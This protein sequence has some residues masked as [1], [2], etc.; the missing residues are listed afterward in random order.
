MRQ[1]RHVQRMGGQVQERH[2]PGAG[3]LRIL[4][5]EGSHGF[6]LEG[7]DPDAAENRF[8]AVFDHQGV[9]RG[10]RRKGLPGRVNLRVLKPE[11][12]AVLGLGRIVRGVVQ[13][14]FRQRLCPDFRQQRVQ[15]FRRHRL[16]RLRRGRQ[17]RADRQHQRKA[18]DL[19]HHYGFTPFNSLFSASICVYMVNYITTPSS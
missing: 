16:R 15:F 18:Q 7:G 9:H 5:R 19:F 4:V 10:I 6:L 1:L 3:Q 17:R 11:K 14:F 12:R 8:L 13:R 2:V